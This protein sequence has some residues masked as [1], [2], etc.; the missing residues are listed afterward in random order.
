MESTLYT[1]A[2]LQIWAAAVTRTGS[3]DPRR[4][5]AMLKSGGP[6]TS[7]LGETSFDGKGDPTVPDFVFYRWSNGTYAE[8]A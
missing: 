1:Y 3:E 8:I 5:A 4:V 7:V 2:T 6:W